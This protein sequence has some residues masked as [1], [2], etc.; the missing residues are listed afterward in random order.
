[1]KSRVLA[2]LLIAA[3]L[4]ARGAALTEDFSS[5]PTGSGWL[6]FGNTNLFQWDATNQDLEVTWDSS[7][8]NSYFYHSLGTTLS[9]RDDFAIGFDLLL[10]DINSGTEPDKTG[11]MEIAVGLLNFATASRTNF[12]RGAYGHAPGLVEFNYF[13]SG[14]YNSEGMF[15]YVAPTTTPTFISTNA[16]HFAPTIFAPYEFELPLGVS[17]RVQMTYAAS[18]QTLSTVL[19]TNGQIFLQLPDVLLTDTNTSNFRVSD[20]F[21]VDTL[22]ISS[23]SSAGDPFDSVLAH[24]TVGNISV[25]FPLPIQDLAGAPSS[26]GWQVQFT[27]LTN[28]LYT[29]QRTADF[30]QWSSVATNMFGTGGA[31]LLRDA[32]APPGRAFYRVRAD[33]L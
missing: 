25:T 19:T 21:R 15:F 7:Q 33:H 22:S 14:Y 10:N 5:N 6:V 2:L 4:P 11:P 30:S 29:L 20:D 28:W 9:R 27:G 32:N 8:P 24:G 18:N 1:M 31:T 17:V 23:Y 13:P 26:G 12:M 3:A 16:T